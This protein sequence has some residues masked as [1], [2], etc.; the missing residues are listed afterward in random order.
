MVLRLLRASFSIE[1]RSGRDS[2][3][4]I[5]YSSFFSCSVHESFKP[6]S[7]ARDCHYLASSESDKRPLQQS[8]LPLGYTFLYLYRS[9]CA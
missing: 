8:H 9:A 3:K 1:S 2:S 4:S 6:L 5:W 7:S